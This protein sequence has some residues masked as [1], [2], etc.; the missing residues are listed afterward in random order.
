MDGNPPQRGQGKF[1]DGGPVS[2]HSAMRKAF[3]RMDG[4]PVVEPR[5]PELAFTYLIWMPYR[6]AILELM[7]KMIAVPV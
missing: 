4:I 6:T 3:A 5:P 1:S 7:G 2:L